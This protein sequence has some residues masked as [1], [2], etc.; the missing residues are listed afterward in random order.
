MSK[1]AIEILLITVAVSVGAAAEAPP[2][3]L[4]EY[5]HDARGLGLDEG[6]IR[7]NALSAGWEANIVDEAILTARDPLRQ[8][9]DP[10]QNNPDLPDGYRIGAG[11]ILQVSVYK[12]PE[13]SV[14]S[15]VVRSDGKISLPLVKEIAV[16]G[17][18]PAEA[19][20]LL[21][22][23]IGRYIRSA[24]V[25]LIVKE[26]HSKRVYLVGAVKA[27]GPVEMKGRMTVLQAITQAG[28]LSDFAKRKHVYVLRN[29]NGRQARLPFNYDAV[30]RGEKIEQNIVL[31]PDDTI[32][33]PQ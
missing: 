9:K 23:Q 7:R 13:A 11:D 31:A 32:V 24:D 1:F 15:A 16:A 2:K 18:T 33:V 20:R 25:T 4:V 6:R 14:P 3:E 12:E 30:I 19:E 10:A 5:V 29:E 8:S 26:V 28:G 22:Q 27:V 17:L 21:S